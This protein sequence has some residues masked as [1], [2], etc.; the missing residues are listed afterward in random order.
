VIVTLELLLKMILLSESF[1]LCFASTQRIF[2]SPVLRIIITIII[3]II[4]IFI[5]IIVINWNIM[6]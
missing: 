1:V 4:F 3:I 6:L 2:H 5:V